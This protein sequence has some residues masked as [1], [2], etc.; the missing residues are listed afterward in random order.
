MKIL[1]IDDD[2]AVRKF[3][4]TTLKRANH[5]VLEAENGAEGL[6]VL[7]EERDIPVVIT[8]LIMPE[9]EGVETIIEVKQLY[10]S[11]KILAISGGG[12]AGP[13]NYLVLADALGANTTLKKPFSGQDLM[14]A[15]E[16]L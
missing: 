3:I 4:G 8:D 2:A 9:K 15:V 13:E 11:I 5:T 12:K 6:R 7:L 1:V 16:S 10:P 14:R